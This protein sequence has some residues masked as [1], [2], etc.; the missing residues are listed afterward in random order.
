M[1]RLERQIALANAL[2]LL[3]LQPGGEPRVP[4]LPGL[5]EPAASWAMATY[6]R[7]GGVLS[8]PV[9]Q[10]LGWDIPTTSGLIV[11]LDE[12]QHFNRYRAATLN[13]RWATDLPWRGDYLVYCA[14]FERVALKGH[15]GRGFWA[16]DGSVAQF[17]P[18]GPR[19]SIEGAGSPRWKQRAVY[20]AL[21]DTAAADGSVT[22]ARLSVHDRLGTARLGDALRG[23]AP[24]DLQEL[25]ALVAKRTLGRDQLA[26]GS[27]V[28]HVDVQPATPA[29]PAELAAVSPA[30]EAQTLTFEPAELARKLGYHDESRPGRIVRAYLRKRYPHH[31]KNAPWLLDEQQARDVLANVPRK[32]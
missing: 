14:E 2:Q 13:M 29:A 22:L 30:N 5:P 6:R 9:L 23:Y 24:L 21:R 10:P 31:P 3:G 32:G 11:E 27:H 18:A 8:A 12:E 19:R 16:S 28:D 7:L 26:Y 17:G 1:A 4:R 15:S 25:Y 20:D